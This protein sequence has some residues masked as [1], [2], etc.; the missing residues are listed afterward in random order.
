MPKW[1]SRVVAVAVAGVA[2]LALS[3]AGDGGGSGGGS[4][5]PSGEEY[6][7]SGYALHMM[8]RVSGASPAPTAGPRHAAARERLVAGSE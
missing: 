2:A 1:Q 5:R 4:T 3:C 7:P 8:R 6:A